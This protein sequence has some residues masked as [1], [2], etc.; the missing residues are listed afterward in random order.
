MFDGYV[1]VDLEATCD[2]RSFDHTIRETIEIGAVRLGR[3]GTEIDG[4]FQSFVRPTE[5]SLLSVYCRRLTGITQAD[6]EGAPAFPQ[7]WE[8]F[9]RW[10]GP[11]DHCRFCS[12]GGF[13]RR[14]L[15]QDCRRHRL[16]IPPW[17]EDHLDLRRLY[18]SIRWTR[19]G[20][21][22]E[23]LRREKI[24]FEGRLHRAVDDARAIA[25]IASRI[26]P[27]L[28]TRPGSPESARAE[29]SGEAEVP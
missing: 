12:W 17:I 18:A 13:D 19:A 7:A 23:A 20:T 21:M 5:L 24:P 8:R 6:L 2:R 25:R 29:S 27:I 14:Q 16:E 28:E 9:L 26:L 1:I 4:T 3:G 10:V 15:I 11:L 22:T